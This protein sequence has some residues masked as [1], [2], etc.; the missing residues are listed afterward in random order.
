MKEY[1][2]IQLEDEEAQTLLDVSRLMDDEPVKSVPFPGDIDSA[3]DDVDIGATYW[4]ENNHVVGLRF[5]Q[6]K[7]KKLPKNIG[8]NGLFHF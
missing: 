5:L 4:Y 8:T 3:L 6:S 7:L 2:S 1:Y